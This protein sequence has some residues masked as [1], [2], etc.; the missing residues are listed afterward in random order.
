MDPFEM[1]VAI[2]AIACAAGVL[3]TAI[4]SRRKN[5]VQDAEIDDLTDRL[6]HAVERRFDK[7]EGRIANIESIVLEREKLSKFDDL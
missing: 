5:R 1:V 7:L 6:E 4:N 2:V 3:K